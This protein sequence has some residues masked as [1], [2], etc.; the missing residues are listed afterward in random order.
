[1]TSKYKDLESTLEVEEEV[2]DLKDEILNVI[3][4]KYDYHV[5]E[6]PK[7]DTKVEKLARAIVKESRQNQEECDSNDEEDSESSEEDLEFTD[8]IDS[9]YP[10]DE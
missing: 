3:T 10:S 9:Y 5:G 4:E 8:Q 7:I 1:M 6:D 2:R